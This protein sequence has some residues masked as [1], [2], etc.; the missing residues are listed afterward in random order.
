SDFIIGFPGETDADFG[1]TMDLVR[2]VGFAAA[3]SFKYSPRPGTP[4]AG[5]EGH[6]P[7]AVMTERLHAL[8]ALVTAQQRAFQD[9]LVGQV[10]DV[11]FEK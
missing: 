6:L 7:D 5:I 11:L 1:D 10:V 2:Q 4:A 3:Y 8:Q 9:S